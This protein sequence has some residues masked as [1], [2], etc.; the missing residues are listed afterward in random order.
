MK[1]SHLTNS[2]ICT[3]VLTMVFS[4]NV[5]KAAQGT[6]SGGGGDL[7]TLDFVKTAN[8]SVFPWLIK[9]GA[10]L[11]PVVDANDFIQAV[12][13]KDIASLE[14]V[15]ESCDDTERGR[16]VAACYN[17]QT[18]KIFLSRNLYPLNQDGPAKIRLVAHEIFRKMGIEGD[19][20]EVTKQISI[21]KEAMVYSAINYEAAGTCWNPKSG[22]VRDTMAASEATGLAALNVIYGTRASGYVINSACQVAYEKYLKST[23]NPR[24]VTSEIMQ[25][26]GETGVGNSLPDGSKNCG[27]N[28][29]IGY[30]KY[31]CTISLKYEN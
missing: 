9:N 2:L 20:Y 25:A 21:T 1:L 4:T 27:K 28:G 29:W 11:S 8:Q 7:Y 17:A 14:K 6:N 19:A 10:N 24:A 15:F 16:E 3:L 12:S 5:A 30:V 18:N 31:S 26:R 23:K 13:P 22:D